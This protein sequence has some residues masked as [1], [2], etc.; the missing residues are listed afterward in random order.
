MEGLYLAESPE[1]AWAEW[2][3]Y[4][5]ES[6]ILPDQGLPRNLWQWKVDLPA[7]A[8]LSTSGALARVGLH[9]PTPDRSDWQR[10]QTVGEQ[11]CRD[12][13][14]A[15][16]A[17]SAARSTGTVLCIFGGAEEVVGVERIPP[18]Q[19]FISPPPVPKGLTT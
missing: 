1:T 16:I 5:A 13:W 14:K 19:T 4:L 9:K 12:G 6:G 3:R 11:L 8:D 10:F 2:Y 7:A 17:P 18:P 15:M